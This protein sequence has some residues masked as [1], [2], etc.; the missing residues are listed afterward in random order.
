M[1]E[2]V[3]QDETLTLCHS[4]LVEAIVAQYL[5]FFDGLSGASPSQ[6][7]SEARWIVAGGVQRAL[8]RYL[9]PKPMPLLNANSIP[10][11]KADPNSDQGHHL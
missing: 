2:Y 8:L 1:G 7:E 3:P 4:D 9:S 5:E 10:A 6:F 11:L